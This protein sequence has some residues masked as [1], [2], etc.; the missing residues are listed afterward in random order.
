MEDE[1]EQDI[2]SYPLKHTQSQY[3]FGPSFSAVMIE[4]ALFVQGKEDEAD[5]FGV[6]VLAINVSEEDEGVFTGIVT[7]EV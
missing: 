2:L 5:E 3:F 4:M 6:A 7:W 1:F